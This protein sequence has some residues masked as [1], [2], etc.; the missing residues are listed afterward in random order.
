MENVIGAYSNKI[1]EDIGKELMKSK[2][3]EKERLEVIEN[4]ID[5]V[6]EDVIKIR[7]LDEYNGY[8]FEHDIHKTDKDLLIDGIKNLDDGNKIEQLI[9]VLEEKC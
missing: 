3:I 5:S 6:N 1:L 4:I 9:K 8:C 2:I 7:L